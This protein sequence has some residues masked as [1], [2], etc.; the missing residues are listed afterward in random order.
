LSQNTLT[1]ARVAE[2][3]ASIEER[4]PDLMSL[5]SDELIDWCIMRYERLKA[6]RGLTHQ[7]LADMA[8]MPKGTVDRLLAGNYRDFKYSTIQPLIAAMLGQD[9]PAPEIDAGDAEQ[10]E[11]AQEL[12]MGYQMTL[13]EKNSQIPQLLD[14]I[15][16][17]EAANEKRISDI[18]EDS[19]RKVDYLKQQIIR[20]DKIIT[21][22]AV[23][24]GVIVALVIGI[25]I[26]DR[27]NPNVGWFRDVASYFAGDMSASAWP[28]SVFG[29]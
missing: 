11:E 12:L 3:Y 1:Q 19:Q 7:A 10:V 20:K 8:N 15:E 25:L 16:R 21:A 14:H 27:L 2:A 18:R 26:Y 28:F 13:K 22:L 9:E 23:T 17:L 5:T 6:T 4:A 29:K 24:L